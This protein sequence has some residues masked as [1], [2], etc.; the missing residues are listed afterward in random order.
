MICLGVDQSKKFSQYT[1]G[2]EK[3]NIFKKTRIANESEEIQKL[4]ESLPE[5]PRK[6]A[7]E[8]SRHWG[9]LHDELEKYADEVLLGNPLEMKAIAH[10]K[11]K[12]DS[13]DSMTIYHLLRTDLLPTCYVPPKEVREIK[14]QLRFRGFLIMVRG[15][16]KNQIHVLVDRN[17]VLQPGQRET[18]GLFSQK[19]LKALEKVELSEREKKILDELLVLL[20]QLEAQIEIGNQWVEELYEGSPEAKLIDTIPGFAHFLSVFAC[21]EIGE[22]HRF[23]E[24]KKLCAYAGLVPSVYASGEK[25]FYGK[26]TKRGNAHLRWALIEAVSP[27][28]VSDPRLR[29]QYE[30]LREKKGTKVAR[31]AIARKLLEWVYRVWKTGRTFQ[32]LTS[33]AALN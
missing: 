27:S 13:I 16:I 10:A 14:D 6:A 33:Q 1:I 29:T 22:I 7:L 28:V 32:E 8:A 24:A 25:T 21:Y 31:V 5:G 26:I 9:W 3:G 17:H 19:G 30:R 2:D 15:M 18:E 11:V 20:K 4:M 23:R 12:T